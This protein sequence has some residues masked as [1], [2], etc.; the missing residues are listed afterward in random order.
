VRRAPLIGGALQHAGKKGKGIGK[1]KGYRERKGKG[2]R[3]RKGI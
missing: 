3:E 1:G 2:Y